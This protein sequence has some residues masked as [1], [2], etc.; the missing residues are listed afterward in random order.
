MEFYNDPY[1][2]YIIDNFVDD[3]IAYELSNEFMD[4]YSP[5]WFSYDSEIEVK[6]ACNNWYNFPKEKTFGEKNPNKFKYFMEYI[7]GFIFTTSKD[8][9]I[10]YCFS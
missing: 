3:K 2:H 8:K 9:N 5:D 7:F 6:K 10:P 4:F 1:P